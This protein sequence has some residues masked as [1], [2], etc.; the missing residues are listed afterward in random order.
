MTTTAE[1][2]PQVLP[3]AGARFGPRAVALLLDLAA[4]ALLNGAFVSLLGGALA[5]EA[6]R[7]L[8]TMLLLSGTLLGTALLVPPLIGLAYFTIFHACGGQ[9]IGKLLLGLR[10]VDAA[11]GGALPWGRA[12]LRAVGQLVSALP[13]A[14]G[15]LWVLVD[16]ARRAW[17]DSLAGSRVAV[18]EKSLDKEPSIQ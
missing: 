15:F 9:T 11:D 4:L 2:V 12:F 1:M 8:W 17:H 5:S 16:P 13:L 14:A 3:A 18:V 10:V 6:P 7:T